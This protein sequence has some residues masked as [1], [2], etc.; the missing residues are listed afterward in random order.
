LAMEDIVSLAAAFTTMALVAK[1][2]RHIAGRTPAPI[3]RRAG[4]AVADA[5]LSLS[6][7]PRI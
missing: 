3:E 2:T 5:R 1:I 6:R 4:S 7:Q